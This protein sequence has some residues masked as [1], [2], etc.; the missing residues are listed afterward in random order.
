MA[1]T[2]PITSDNGLDSTASSTFR[3]LITGF[4]PFKTHSVNASWEA[5]SLLPDKVPNTN[6]EIFKEQVQVSY[7][8]VDTTVPQLWKKYNPDL[9]IHVGVSDMARTIT[10]ESCGHKDDYIS[11]DI[12]RELPC[13]AKCKAAERCPEPTEQIRTQ[14]NLAKLIEDFRTKKSDLHEALEVDISKVDV[15]LSCNAGRYLCEYIYFTSLCIDSGRCVFIHV[16]VIG[17]PYSLSELTDSLLSII[18][19]LSRELEK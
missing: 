9:V 4:G 10:L 11:H 1:D 7:T 5:V 18:V 17:V 15:T 12:Y 13:D 8:Y 19:L 6:I 3:V 2:T 14:L 16:P